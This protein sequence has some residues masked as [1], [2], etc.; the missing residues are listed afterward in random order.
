MVDAPLVS[1]TQGSSREPITVA[2]AESLRAAGTLVVDE[3]RSRTRW[4]DGRFLAAKDGIRDQNY[5]LTRLADLGRA[6]GTGVVAGLAVTASSATSV[7]VDAGQGITPGGETV[8]VPEPL[9]LALADVAALEQLDVAFGL[10]RIPRELARNRSGLYVLGLRPVEYTANPVASYPTTLDGPRSVQDGDIVEAAA[11]VLVPYA[12]QGPQ[13]T[14]ETRRSRV[15]RR[16]F[17]DEGGLGVPANVLPLAMIAL[18]RGVVRWTDMFMVRREVGADAAREVGFGFSP[19]ALREAY[20][21]QYLGQLQEI[22]AARQASNLSLRFA[23]SEYFAAL[24]PAGAL[25]AAAI[26]A[27]DFSQVFFPPQIATDLSIVPEDELPIVVEDSTLLPPIDLGAPADEL[28]ATSVQVLVPVPRPMLPRFEALLGSVTRSLRPSAPGLLFQR[29]P[30][31]SLMGLTA[32]RRP[33]PMLDAQNPIVTAWRQALA[34][35]PLLW[36][37]RRR[38]LQVR[39][40]VM[41]AVVRVEGDEFAREKLLSDALVTAGLTT[42]FA[43]VSTRASAPANAEIVGFV[44]S[45]AMLAS[46]V[47]LGSAITELEGVT[48][49]DQAAALQLRARYADPALGQGLATIERLVPAFFMA[50]VVDAVGEAGAAPELDRLGLALTGDAL[51]A[52]ATQVTTLS[53]AEGAPQKVG[54]YLREQAELVP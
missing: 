20:A 32:A 23:A 33:P 19:R 12:E 7:K 42:R 40:D 44:S 35:R 10:S 22:M 6:G 54:A 17:M 47:L 9:T 51:R 49:L 28:E 31:E 34:Q 39:K 50:T 14:A 36:F 18:D 13:G 45:P 38:N 1:F 11:V 24:P 48:R 46:P 3:R 52:V 16:V 4:F 27:G 41:G 15:A 43:V 29:K 8:M 25:P 37:V 30:L 26:D 2:D 5:F 21:L 53:T